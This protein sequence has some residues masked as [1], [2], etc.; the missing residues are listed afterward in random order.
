MARQLL[1]SMSNPLDEDLLPG[2]VAEFAAHL[3]PQGLVN[4]LKEPCCV[5]PTRQHLLG[6]IGTRLN[7]AGP[8]RNY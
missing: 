1:R 8:P 6:K 2:I 4:L 5:G 3:T 7:I